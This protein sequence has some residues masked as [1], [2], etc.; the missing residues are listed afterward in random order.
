[1]VLRLRPP[2]R[3]PHPG[4]VLRVAHPPVHHMMLMVVHKLAEHARK[5]LL[6][7]ARR[8]LLSRRLERLRCVCRVPVSGP[9]VP[10]SP[11]GAV[12]VVGAMILVVGIRF[13]R[14]ILNRIRPV[15]QPTHQMSGIL[16][17]KR[18]LRQWQLCLRVL[19]HGIRRLQC[20]PSRR[21][22]L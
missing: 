12:V 14:L 3:F 20:L 19:P 10:A 1:M 8:L 13:L 15:N 16:R 18:F 6:P 4:R 11:L 17:H 9:T 22:L 2:V 5:Q 7:H 21:R